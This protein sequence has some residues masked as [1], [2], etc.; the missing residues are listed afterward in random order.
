MNMSQ[1]AADLT[2][3][4]KGKSATQAKPKATPAKPATRPAKAAAK[5][6]T[7]PAKATPAQAKAKAERAYKAA[8]SVS[9][10]SDRN[11]A[12]WEK[13]KAGGTDAQLKALVPGHASFV[14][15]AIKRGWLV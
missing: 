14:A 8:E 15:Y 3:A 1:L 9:I 6:A 10:K 13:I 7:R 4:V 12:S 5:P 2:N 11:A